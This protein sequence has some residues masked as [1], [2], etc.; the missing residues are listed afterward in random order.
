M[1]VSLNLRTLNNASPQTQTVA[2]VVSLVAG[3]EEGLQCG[4]H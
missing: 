2:V 3:R 1:G 4:W